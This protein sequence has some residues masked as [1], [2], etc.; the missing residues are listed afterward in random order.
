MKNQFLI[1]L[2]SMMFL[3]C[4]TPPP[5]AQ[6]S[7]AKV[8]S[9][10]L[11]RI[12]DFPSKHIEPRHV[13]IWLPEG[14]TADKK[15]PVL[16]MHDGQMLFDA[17]IGWNG[18][19]WGVDE[20]M[21]QLLRSEKVR[22]A[23]MVGIW[24][25]GAMR[26]SDYFPQKPF[27]SLRRT[28]RDS[29]MTDAK[30]DSNTPLF[31]GAVQSDN[32]LKFIVEELKPHIDQTYSTLAD[33]ENTFIAGSSMGGL[34]SMYALC[35]YPQVFGQ[36]ACL[37][38]HWVG[39]FETEGNPIPQAF[40]DYLNQHLP[41]SGTHRWYFDYGTA[42]L[43]ALYEPYQLQANQIFEQKGYGEKD[44]LA[45]KFAG[46]NHSENAW[47]KRLHIPLDFLLGKK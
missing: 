3:H 24:N 31:A 6:T 1:L 13:E 35:E 42:T 4:S 15:Y 21:G 7:P 10:S 17:S 30:R 12:S 25:S 37:S 46:A 28:Y 45:L 32:Y 11:E 20:V 19:E 8:D 29:L 40:M 34:I 27:E 44:W 18:Q 22:P 2:T 16:Y 47:R 38:T 23:I 14:Y 33:R 36:A 26:H 9:G 5:Q 43:D 39:I 41:P